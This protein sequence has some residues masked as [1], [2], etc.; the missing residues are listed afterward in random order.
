[1]A[2][3][4]GDPSGVGFP[5]TMWS[6]VLSAGQGSSTALDLMAR[7]YR[8]VVLK[9]VGWY[10]SGR[11]V[12]HDPEDVTQE[13]FLHLMGRQGEIFGSADPSRGRFR[14]WLRACLRNWLNNWDDRVRAAKRGGGV[15][16]TSLDWEDGVGDSVAAPDDLD[17]EFD[18]EWARDVVARATAKLRQEGPAARLEPHDREV[19]DLKFRDENLSDRA[20]AERLGLHENDVLTSLRRSKR[21]FRELLRGEVL[22]TVASEAEVEEE[23]SELLRCLGRE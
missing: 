15:H 6:K 2:A 14:A 11:R 3:N 21:R 9:L 5:P 10:V 17:A 18:R 23:V 22:P 20:I 4:T 7:W 13:F 12:R 1:M 8:P 16:E 19:W